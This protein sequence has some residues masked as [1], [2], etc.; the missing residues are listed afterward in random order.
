MG[1]VKNT[2]HWKPFNR[3]AEGNPKT[4]T[5]IVS[6]SLIQH[7]ADAALELADALKEGVGDSGQLL[8]C[9]AIKN[10][11]KADRNATALREHLVNER[12]AN[13]ERIKKELVEV[14]KKR[15]DFLEKE[16]QIAPEAER[17]LQTLNLQWKGPGVISPLAP[18][19]PISVEALAGLENIPNQLVESNS[20]SLDACAVVGGGT[21]LGV[22]LGSLLGQLEL[23]NIANEVPQ[24]AILALCGM[25]IMGLVGGWLKPLAHTVGGV[26]YR[27]GVGSPVFKGLVAATWV[28]LLAVSSYACIAIESKVDQNGL[29]KAIAEGRRLTVVVLD[30]SEML[31]VSMLLVLPVIGMYVTGK[32]IAGFSQAAQTHLRGLHHRERQK[33][34]TSAD[35]ATLC[36]ICPILAPVRRELIRL[37]QKSVALEASLRYA[38]SE[39]ELHQIED[40]E[41]DAITYS[42]EAKALVYPHPVYGTVQRRRVWS[43]LFGKVTKSMKPG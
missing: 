39:Q 19:E 3:D 15:D 10:A 30:R 26:I 40:A 4:R 33:L 29:F 5:R 22:S 20:R 2:G 13:N 6:P 27:V 35:Y 28:L 18:D 12:N 16:S 37:E 8:K 23:S 1:D 31:I 9:Q 24:F 32:L 36:E 41:N 25:A 34:L 43:W 42:E 38:F 14:D 21:V 11:I 17:L 7:D